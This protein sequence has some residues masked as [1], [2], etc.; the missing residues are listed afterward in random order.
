MKAKKVLPRF[1][2]TVIITIVISAMI[3]CHFFPRKKE[4]F[5]AGYF[6]YDSAQKATIVLN[7]SQYFAT[8]LRPVLNP[9]IDLFELR[10]DGYGSIYPDDNILSGVTD[11]DFSAQMKKASDVDNLTF[12]LLFSMNP[13]A[14]QANIEALKKNNPELHTFY[15]DLLQLIAT[16]DTDGFVQKWQD[17]FFPRYMEAL[18]A[19]LK[20]TGKDSL[21]FFIHGYNVPY[22]LAYVQCIELIKHAAQLGVDTSK[23][24]F[25][26]VYWPSNDLKAHKLDQGR[27]DTHNKI[28][29]A[30]KLGWERYS[31]R[32]FYAAFTFRSILDKLDSKYNVRIMSHSLG[33]TVATTALIN[34]HYK[35]QTDYDS[36]IIAAPGSL[37]QKYMNSLHAGDRITYDFVLAMR[38]IPIP[39]RPMKIFM[40]VPAIP[41][42]TTFH[43]MDE[44]IARN[45]LF[46]V[47]WNPKDEMVSKNLIPIIGSPAKHGSTTF[48]ANARNK[49]FGKP[50]V[51]VVADIFRRFGA[52]SNFIEC[53]VGKQ[54][55][56]DIFRYYQETGFNELLKQFFNVH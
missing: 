20:K 6:P 37:S 4:Q 29:F 46:Y 23:Y 35:L 44:R 28:G 43:D 15:R 11:T 33:A 1:C 9:K 10:L 41:G 12:Y 45:C 3:S 50:E 24:L 55:D 39:S 48:G 8:Q 26:P 52:V 7:W 51:D 18:H 38:T 22:S 5:K 17:H 47:G 2:F 34:T 30:N 13:P 25:V 42:Y 14:L 54:K 27:F 56:H 36:V 16:K 32:A 49:E 21:V 31:N 19:K 53:R 40:N